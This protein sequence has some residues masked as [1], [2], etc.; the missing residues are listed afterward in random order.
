M[1]ANYT[2][3]NERVAK[4]YGIRGIY[5]SRFRRVTLTDERRFGLLGK[6][7]VL[8]VTS[9]AERTSPVERGKWILENIL[10]LP[11]PPPPPIPGAGS[12]AEPAPGEA[13]KTMRQQMEVHRANPVCAS[14]HKVMD[15]IGLSLENFDVVGAWRTEDAGSPIDATG[16]LVD[17]THVDGIVT[18]R[19]ALL[20]HP[21]VFVRTMTEKMMIYALGRGLDARDMPSVRAIMR[22][23]A[24][25]DSRFS[26][27]VLGIVHS[28]PFTMRVAQ[29][30]ASV[31]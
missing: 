13:P 3:I 10:N 23:A 22:D 28:T 9:H 7:S 5:G 21:E 26:S 14:C 17:G 30:P 31:N 27:L 8:T 20:A 1:S 19:K 12:F 29:Q 25:H 24:P 4:H 18:L 15:P 11:I 16:Q 2:F 6:G